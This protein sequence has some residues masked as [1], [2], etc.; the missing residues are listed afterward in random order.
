M[1][2]LSSLFPVT[3]PLYL[4]VSGVLL[5]VSQTCEPS[6]PEELDLLA[7]S[8]RRGHSVRSVG[9]CHVQSAAQNTVMLRQPVSK[10]FYTHGT[11]RAILTCH[12]VK[13]SHLHLLKSTMVFVVSWVPIGGKKK[14]YFVFA[15]GKQ[16]ESAS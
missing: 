1:K 3:P 5:S 15:W 11:Y 6:R 2:S 7:E 12:N 10:C 9:L 14:K 4:S 13:L 8:E 16:S